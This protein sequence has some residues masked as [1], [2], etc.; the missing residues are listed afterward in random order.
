MVLP[1]I[2]IAGSRKSDHGKIVIVSVVHG[3][4]SSVEPD[5]V[6]LNLLECKNISARSSSSPEELLAK[7]AK[8]IMIL[9]DQATGAQLSVDVS[10]FEKCL[11][12]ILCS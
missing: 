4:Q 7:P 8:S 3:V 5:L 11:G 2:N 9:T 10:V 12:L 1:I 6:G